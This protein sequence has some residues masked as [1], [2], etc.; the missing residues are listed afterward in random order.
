M[1]KCLQFVLFT[2]FLGSHVA[3]CMLASSKIELAS[4]ARIK[5]I[6]FKAVLNNKGEKTTETYRHFLK[7]LIHYPKEAHTTNHFQEPYAA[8][9]ICV[10]KAMQGNDKPLMPDAR[11]YK[12]IIL[13]EDVLDDYRKEM[14]RLHESGEGDKNQ[15][16]QELETLVK[17]P[18]NRLK[19]ISIETCEF[20]L[21]RL[22]VEELSSIRDTLMEGDNAPEGINPVTYESDYDIKSVEEEFRKRFQQTLNAERINFL[23]SENDGLSYQL[24]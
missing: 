5:L 2:F 9:L 12:K 7:V 22:I 8:S 13:K 20:T 3:F 15:R 23:I 18:E 6:P 19:R 16:N 4:T 24:L 14:D 17:D 1:L 10:C 21:N 11:V